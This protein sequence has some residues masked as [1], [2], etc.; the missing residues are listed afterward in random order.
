MST[1]GGVINQPVLLIRVLCA[2]YE[3]LLE[4]LH[5]APSGEAFVGD[6]PR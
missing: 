6:A 4:G 5:L 1:Q 3:G 2:S